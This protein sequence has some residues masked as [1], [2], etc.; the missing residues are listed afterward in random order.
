M[1][2]ATMILYFTL[3]QPIAFVTSDERRHF[4]FCSGPVDPR[5]AI[6]SEARI[7]QKTYSMRG[8]AE[9]QTSVI[10]LTTAPEVFPS[11]ADASEAFRQLSEDWS[12]ET[13]HV[14]SVKDLT[15][16]PS[17]QGI[18]K[19][20]WDAVPLLLRDLQENKRFWFPALHAITG[21]RPF[22]KR[23]AGNAR[24]MTEAWIVWGRK[25]GII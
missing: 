1:I 3:S 2:P 19:L 10:E 7:A 9:M 16:H 24:K 14:S 22:D 11:F 20:G 12:S 18:I 25:K 13:R 23:D 5:V 21:V 4:P 15:S 8:G 6:Y 17:Y